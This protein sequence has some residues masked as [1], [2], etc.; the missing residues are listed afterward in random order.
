M[1]SVPAHGKGCTGLSINAPSTSNHNGVLWFCGEVSN[2]VCTSVRCLTS[3][4]SN[5]GPPI[6]HLLLI[7]TSEFC[8]VP[9]S[10]F[11]WSFPTEITNCC[12]FSPSP[13][14]LRQ[15]CQGSCCSYQPV[16]LPALQLVTDVKGVVFDWRWKEN[17]CSVRNNQGD[18]FA[19]KRPWK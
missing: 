11:P 12:S 19:C 15:R 4:S 6:T 8:Q 5:P 7:I 17:Q 9:F 14:S 1:E 18:D 10:L 13:Q 3:G 16:H 2:L